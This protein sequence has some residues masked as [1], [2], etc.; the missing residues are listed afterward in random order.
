MISE[1]E[2][3]RFK[4]EKVKLDYIKRER[5][6]ELLLIHPHSRTS[7]HECELAELLIDYPCF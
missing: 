5:I 4:K 2:V 1:A 7:D 6:N 3:H